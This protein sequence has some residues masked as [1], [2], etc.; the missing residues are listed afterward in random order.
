MSELHERLAAE[1]FADGGVVA[2]NPSPYAGTW[3]YVLVRDGEIV[4][5]RSGY[6]L[7][8]D[9]GRDVVTN[10]NSEL[11]AILAVIS[12]LPDGFVGRV[13]SDSWIALGWVFQN[14]KTDSIPPALLAHLD[15]AKERLKSLRLTW[16][17]L[18]GHPTKDQLATGRGK[19]G[20]PVS[21]WNARCDRVCS[22]LAAKFERGGSE[23]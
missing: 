19:R 10:N 17:L 14:Y 23:G 7:P 9:I 4:H 3:A 1:I 6:L 12:Q 18:D 22:E 8:T 5:D 13:N 11:M 21:E 16:R 2:V 15:A 20:N